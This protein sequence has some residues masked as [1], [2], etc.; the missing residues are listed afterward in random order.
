MANPNPN[1]PPQPGY[2]K[3]LATSAAGALTTIVAYVVHAMLGID[4]P[5]EVAAAGTTLIAG[6]AQFFMPEKYS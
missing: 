2:N 3:L 5:A 1:P 4:V 6:A